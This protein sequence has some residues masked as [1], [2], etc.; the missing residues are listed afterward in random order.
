VVNKGSSGSWW[1][2]HDLSVLAPDGKAASRAGTDD[3]IQR[4]NAAL[5]DGTRLT[6]VYNSGSGTATFDV[7]WG[8]TTYSYR[9]PAGAAAIF[10]TRSA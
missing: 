3:G 9:L 2:I 4:K 6:A 1:S 5:P 7:P 8:G 10:T